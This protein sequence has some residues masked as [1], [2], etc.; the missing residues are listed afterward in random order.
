MEHRITEILDFVHRPGL[1]N[2]YTTILKLGL[3]PFSEDGKK[4]PARLGP[5]KTDNLIHWI[6]Y[7]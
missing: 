2:Q 1:E 5:L 4:I 7:F 3:F 6:S